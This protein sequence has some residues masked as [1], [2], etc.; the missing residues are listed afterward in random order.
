MLP[1]SLVISKISTQNKNIQYFVR[2]SSV[3]FEKLVK[4]PTQKSCMTSSIKTT[5]KKPP[6]KLN[7]LKLCKNNLIVKLS[8]IASNQQLDLSYI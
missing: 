8:T 4:T 1:I 3:I 6:I 2:N 5:F 7:I